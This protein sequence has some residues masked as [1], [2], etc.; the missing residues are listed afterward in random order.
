MISHKNNKLDIQKKSE[1]GKLHNSHS[2]R[3]KLN[4]TKLVGEKSF[5]HLIN[6]KSPKKIKF[7]IAKSVV[8]DTSLFQ[9]YVSRKNNSQQNS[10]LTNANISE[11]I[12][13][14]KSVGYFVK[15]LTDN[16]Y[17]FQNKIV[18]GGFLVVIA[19]RKRIDKN[20]PPFDV[21]EIKEY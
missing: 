20:L 8:P 21:E 16:K 9:T 17:L 6:T 10:K 18:S 3:K 1:L 19:N 5:R 7:I 15:H 4:M 2:V 13:W 14:L 12:E 11:V